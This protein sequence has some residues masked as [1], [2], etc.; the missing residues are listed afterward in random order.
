MGSQ[1]TQIMFNDGETIAFVDLNKVSNLTEI[2]GSMYCTYIFIHI[3]MYTHT[4]IYIYNYTCTQIATN[5]GWYSKKCGSNQP[6]LDCDLSEI[7]V[8][9]IH[10]NQVIERIVCATNYSAHNL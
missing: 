3:F 1:A 2:N 8:W 7:D 4:G 6:S 5:S 10:D 9:G